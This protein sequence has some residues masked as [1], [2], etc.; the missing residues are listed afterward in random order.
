MGLGVLV[1]IGEGLSL[2]RVDVSADTFVQ[3]LQDFLFGQAFLRQS[4]V[5]Q[6]DL[7]LLQRLLCTLS[8]LLLKAL[9]FFALDEANSIDQP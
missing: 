9:L 6:L 8:G 4:V 1:D 7:F 5:G 3:Y 2:G